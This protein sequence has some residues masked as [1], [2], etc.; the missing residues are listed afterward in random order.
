MKNFINN[1]SNVRKAVSQFENHITVFD[2]YD[3]P[4]YIYQSTDEAG[5]L[6][7]LDWFQ[8][9]WKPTYNSDQTG[10]S[11]DSGKFYSI[12]IVPVCTRIAPAGAPILG[13]ATQPSMARA[14]VGGGTDTI[15]FDI[16]IHPQTRIIGLGD[17]SANDT[18]GIIDGLQTWTTD[19]FVGNT[20]YDVET[21]EMGTITAN[22]L[23]DITVAGFTSTSGDRYQILDS[24]ITQRLIYASEAASEVLTVAGDFYL[25]GIVDD[26][27]TTTFDLTDPPAIGEAWVSNHF[28]PP[29]AA[30]CKSIGGVLFCA[31]G[32]EESR[33][34]AS[35][36]DTETTRTATGAGAD[37]IAVSVA[38]DSYNGADAA[39]IMRY[40][41]GANLS[42]LSDV[43]VGSVVSSTGFTNSENDI[44]D[45][46]VKQ[47]DESNRWFD[48]LN[49]DGVAEVDDIDCE[50]VITANVITGNA[51]GADQTYFSEG[52]VDGR[53]K[54]D[55]DGAISPITVDWVD[56]VTQQIGLRVE[57]NGNNSA[58]NTYELQSDYGLYYSDSR[59][60]HRFRVE[61]L[62]DA[63]ED[64]I[65]S[66]SSVGKTV[67]IFCENSL[68]G[69]DLDSLGSVPRLISD[70]V[71]CPAPFSVVETE[72][73]VL[74]FD[75]EGFSV[76]DG[77]N[78][79]SLTAF[80]AIDYLSQINRERESEIIGVYD[81][82]NKRVEFSFTLGTDSQNNYGLHLTVGSWNVFPHSRPDANALWVNYEN[83]ESFVYHGTS[84]ELS[85]GDGRIWKHDG[86]TDGLRDSS[87]YILNIVEVV[88]QTA[89]VTT[90]GE[91]LSQIGDPI[92]FYP[93]GGGNYREMII[94]TITQIATD[95]YTYEITFNSEYDIT[96]WNIDDLLLVGLIPFDFGV[97]WT[98]FSSPQYLHQVRALH[99][100]VN[101][102]YGV[103]YIDHYYDL[104]EE[105]A[106]TS[107]FSTTPAES[108]IVVPVKLGKGYNYG[109]RM[110]GYSLRQ[111]RIY[112]FIVQFDTHA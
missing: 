79:T 9:Y 30:F 77:I 67:L 56:S 27:T 55:A 75:G 85:D 73:G 68:Y 49:N 90:D 48:V 70:N 104:G 81:R 52:M 54:F 60:P 51:S 111:A 89:T 69:L 82:K 112:D 64:R 86:A 105:P 34:K 102:L 33:G 92:T 44:T 71:R 16:P 21:G 93:N 103:L 107:V 47:V 45:K 10:G 94:E 26:N 12:I 88:D 72:F 24:F 62:S 80:K 97:K 29:N 32:I 35:Y 99:I 101:N 17:C 53:I 23:T 65:K 37:S 40:T 59:N 14:S 7:I 78:V 1:T 4:R 83:G 18:D 50:V 20:L 87:S 96:A 36:D 46:L 13:N 5:Y 84:G 66:L 39:K 74:F 109:F 100:D 38:D 43:Y 6:G 41:L 8:Y 61:N 91:V 106:G 25:A 98:D 58:D 3:R 108:K 63:F 57:Y 11:L 76:T 19:Q 28:P 31:G 110:R 95:P 15:R 42:D 22:G 2:G